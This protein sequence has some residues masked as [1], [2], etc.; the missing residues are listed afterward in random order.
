MNVIDEETVDTMDPKPQLAPLSTKFFP[1]QDYLTHRRSIV[2]R[3]EGVS[4]KFVTP[5]KLFSLS[6]VLKG[7]DVRERSDESDES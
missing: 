3:E 5:Q 1:Y 6:Q 2:Q 7:K 4:S